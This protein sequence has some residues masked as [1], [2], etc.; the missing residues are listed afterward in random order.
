MGRFIVDFLWKTTNWHDI[1]LLS[2]DYHSDER[3]KDWSLFSRKVTQNSCE[4]F[5]DCNWN[6]WVGFALRQRRIYHE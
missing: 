2:N 5:N 4:V 1:L 6:E 3:S